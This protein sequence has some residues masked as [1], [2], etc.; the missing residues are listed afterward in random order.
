LVFGCWLWGKT[1]DWVRPSFPQ[2]SKDFKEAGKRPGFFEERPLCPG[3]PWGN[4]QMP[5]FL[6]PGH[7]SQWAGLLQK[8][9]GWKIHFLHHFHKIRAKPCPDFFPAFFLRRNF[10][11]QLNPTKLLFGLF[12]N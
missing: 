10:P 9:L 8:D 2:I 3:F 6:K 12:F 7:F 11:E 5:V 4:A 1:E